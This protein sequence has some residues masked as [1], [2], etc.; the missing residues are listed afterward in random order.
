MPAVNRQAQIHIHR[1]G[2]RDHGDLAQPFV[3]T[4]RQSDTRIGRPATQ[5]AQRLV[6]Q[7]RDADGVVAGD[8]VT[9]QIQGPHSIRPVLCITGIDAAGHTKAIV[10]RAGKAGNSSTGIE[11]AR[12]G[13]HGGKEGVDPVTRREGEGAAVTIFPMGM[14]QAHVVP[15]LMGDDGTDRAINRHGGEGKLLFIRGLEVSLGTKATEIGQPAAIELGALGAEQHHEVRAIL[16][17]QAVH[18]GEC[19]VLSAGQGAQGAVHVGLLAVAHGRHVHRTQRDG[20][21]AVGIDLVGHGNQ[22]VDAGLCSAT[23]ESVCTRRVERHHVDHGLLGGHR[24]GGRRIGAEQGL[25]EVAD[26]IVVTVPDH[27]F[28]DIE[29]SIMT[30]LAHHCGA[31]DAWPGGGSRRN[32]VAQGLDFAGGEI[33]QR[34]VQHFLRAHRAL[35]A[36]ARSAHQGAVLENKIE[37]HAQGFVPLRAGIAERGQYFGIAPGQHTARA[38]K[39]RDLQIARID[40]G[41]S[42][43]T[44]CAFFLPVAE[45]QGQG[46]HGKHWQSDRAGR[47]SFGNDIVLL[48]GRLAQS[49]RLVDPPLKIA[50]S[51]WTT[52]VQLPDLRTDFSIGKDIQLTGCQ[53]K[54]RLLCVASQLAAQRSVAIE[55][56]RFGV[57]LQACELRGTRQLLHRNRHG[58]SR[59]QR[60]QNAGI[61]GHWHRLC[62]V[63]RQG[64]H[65]SAW[66]FENTPQGR[67]CRLGICSAG[68]HQE[69]PDEHQKRRRR[70]SEQ[71]L[72]QQIRHTEDGL[73]EQFNEFIMLSRGNIFHNLI[74]RGQNSSRMDGDDFGT[75][76]DLSAFDTRIET[77]HHLAAVHG[78]QRHACRLCAAPHE[79]QKL[80]RRARVPA[81]VPALQ[82]L[83]ACVRPLRHLREPVQNL[84]AD[85]VFPLEHQR[86]V[87][88]HL[89]LEPCHQPRER[90]AGGAGESHDPGGRQRA[91]PLH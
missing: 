56:R 33:A 35:P 90:G 63:C 22:L 10:C 46:L 42:C 54:R 18:L 41:D 45:T 24:A 85:K 20:H 67:H 19:R 61:H 59:L 7:Q 6:G 60:R 30:Q 29:H 50:R 48:Q 79:L 51:L 86:G 21:S 14:G 80:R 11:G 73:Y 91:R 72:Q 69:T 83:P 58:D 17:A 89:L 13:H 68:K 52:D 84:R 81:A 34:T 5:R 78:F 9:H 8:L 28:H 74:A 37:I 75:S 1:V 49:F 39:L 76:R 25:V 38:G 71:A 88:P 43:R 62:G 66:G 15:Q 87:H 40:A 82:H 36:T 32:G 77:P 44:A 27:I 31:D 2:R 57:D 3:E 47:R 26:A 53:H 70:A 12:I 16:L 64:G 55:Q 4:R 65:L 23:I